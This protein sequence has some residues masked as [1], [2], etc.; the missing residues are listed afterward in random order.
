M[1]GTRQEIARRSPAWAVRLFGPIYDYLDMLLVDHGIF[2]VIYPNRHRLG[3]V[4]WRS[5]QPAPH[6]I[7]HL[8]R[9]GVRTIVNLRGERD[10]GSYRLERAACERHGIRLVDFQLKSRAAPE[11]SVILEARTLLEEVEYP[12]LLHCKSGADRVGLMSVLYALFRERQPA[13]DAKRQLDWR[14]GHFRAADTGVLD[15][16]FDRYIAERDDGM[17]RTEG[18]VAAFLDWLEN[19]YDPAT[20]RAGFASRSWSNFVVNRILRRE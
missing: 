15:Y 13:V 10:C 1:A 19:R 17:A 2:R 7:A 18:E 6:Q 11:K 16:F 4:A 3:A 9:L 12:I 14:F 20:V 5:S 8:A